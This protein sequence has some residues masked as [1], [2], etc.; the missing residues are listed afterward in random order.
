MAE[1]SVYIL[2]LSGYVSRRI[3]YFSSFYNHTD[4]QVLCCFSKHLMALYFY[5]NLK[6]LC[7]LTVIKKKIFLLEKLSS[8][9]LWC[10]NIQILHFPRINKFIFSTT[11]WKVPTS[12]VFFI[13][14][15]ELLLP[16]LG[17]T[18]FPQSD[19]NNYANIER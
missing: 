19:K 4:F 13:E 18:Y 16:S 12:R 10:L 14:K 3:K 17:S 11:I 5:L 2:S 7:R 9:L 1:I 8:L 15:I 6:S